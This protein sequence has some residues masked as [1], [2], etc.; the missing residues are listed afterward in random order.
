MPLGKRKSR[1]TGEQNK[2]ILIT[3]LLQSLDRITIKQLINENENLDR[4]KINT[5]ILQCRNRG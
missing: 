1:Q 2:Q 4:L 3:P 5:I